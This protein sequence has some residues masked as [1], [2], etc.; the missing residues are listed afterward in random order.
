LTHLIN[1]GLL[2]S[3]QGFALG[4]FDRCAYRAEEARRKQTLRNVIVD[5]LKPL[6]KPI[7]MGLPF[8]H[9]P[10]NATLPLGALATL[11]ATKGDLVLEQMGVG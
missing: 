8:G 11:D 9:V 4:I 5:R 10:F 6:K 3:V 1:L 2:Q 7:V